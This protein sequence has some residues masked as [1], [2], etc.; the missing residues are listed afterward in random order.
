[1]SRKFNG[2]SD[3]ATFS[4]SISAFSLLTLS[5]WML[6]PTNPTVERVAVISASPITAGNSFDLE[7]R[8][9]NAG[10]GSMTMRGSPGFWVD[11]Y[12]QPTASVWHHYLCTFNRA[13][14]LNTLYIDGAPITLTTRLHN[15]GAYGN[16]TNQAW[17][18]M[19]Y[20]A[21]SWF[22]AGTLAELCVWGGFT[23]SAAQA[24]ALA[25]GAN[26]LSV[27]PDS[28]VAYLPLLGD[29]P[30]PDYSGGRHS[31]TL[32]GTTVAP[33]PGVQPGIIIPRRS[34]QPMPV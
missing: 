8:D 29:S 19:Q 20:P 27:R 15:A 10:V 16:F 9:S 33:H 32:T 28:I 17:F 24:K 22:V 11:T 4:P 5:L 30:E 26:P 6:L 34:F 1:M 12:P 3:G 13:T 18:V 2:T 23:P 14:P 7:P 25:A 31:A 21:N